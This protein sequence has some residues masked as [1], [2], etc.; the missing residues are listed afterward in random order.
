[1]GFL[2]SCAIVSPTAVRKLVSL[3]DAPFWLWTSTV[4]L[5]LSGNAWLI[6]LSARPDSPTPDWLFFSVLVP[7]EPPMKV[8]R[9]TKASQPKIA[10]LRWAALQRP[11]RAARFLLR[12][13]V[14]LL[15]WAS[16][17]QRTAGSR[18]DSALQIAEGCPSRLLGISPTDP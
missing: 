2:W 10:V 8:A 12:S 17:G 4:S 18:Y 7:I 5:A 16:P 1:F 14:G 3:A 15:P 9:M 13:K 6:V 11:A